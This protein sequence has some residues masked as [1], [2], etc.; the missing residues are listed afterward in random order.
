MRRIAI[1][2]LLVFAGCAQRRVRQAEVAGHFHAAPQ[3]V[4]GLGEVS[5]VALGSRHS[6]ALRKNGEVWCW[7]NNQ[8]GQL[9]DGTRQSRS[10]P[11]RVRDLPRAK[12]LAAGGDH[13]CAISED[14]HV[15]CWGRGARGQLG[16]GG[17]DDKLVPTPVAT[18]VAHALALGAEHTC[19]IGDLLPAREEKLGGITR[20]YARANVFCWGAND[21]GQVGDGSR[22]DRAK[23]TAVAIDLDLAQF[24]ARGQR[25]AGMHGRH[26]VLWGAGVDRPTELDS[27]G[28]VNQIALGGRHICA[29]LLSNGTWCWGQNDRGQLALGTVGGSEPDP[30]ALTD[31]PFGFLRAGADFTCIAGHG[32]CAGDNSVGQLG[33]GTVETSGELKQIAVGSAGVHNLW[34]GD[35]HICAEIDF[36]ERKIVCWGLDDCGQLG[37]GAPVPSCQ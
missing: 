22:I 32:K 30:R 26:I 34:A 11:A 2:L 16:N 4:V 24:N 12:D 21:A 25:T 5:S 28:G 27:V 10:T 6:C 29:E 18:P 7:G 23:P 37:T 31:S 15:F 3:A 8:S 9:G 20:K 19:M 1:V 17:S 14:E 36:P 33:D 13:S 35:R